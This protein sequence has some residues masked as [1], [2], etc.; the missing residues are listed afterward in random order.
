MIWFN[1]EFGLYAVAGRFLYQLSGGAW[2]E[3]LDAGAG[4]VLVDIIEY[5]NGTDNYLVVTEEGSATYAI[6]TDGASFSTD[7]AEAV[8]LLATRTDKNGAEG[9]LW[10]IE[11]AK[12]E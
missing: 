3:R 12:E 4:K 5:E 6:S 8:V 10:G 9:I 1:S 11:A 7:V 2:V